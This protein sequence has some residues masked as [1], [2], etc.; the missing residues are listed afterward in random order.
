MTHRIFLIGLSSC[1]LASCGLV[2]QPELGDAVSGP[3]AVA[4]QAGTRNVFV[5]NSSFS[6]E[7][8][9]GSLLRFELNEAG[10]ALSKKDAI[11][12]PRLGAD[13]VG[14]ADGSLFAAAFSEGTSRLKFFQASRDGK[15]EDL[16]F[17]HPTPRGIAS[18]LQF[19]V[20]KEAKAGESFLTYVE[21]PGSIESRVVVLKITKA[22]VRT[23]L[24]LPDDLPNGVPEGYGFGYTAPAFSRESSVFVAFPQ[25]ATGLEPKLPPVFEYLKGAWNTV[26]KENADLR[27]VSMAVVQLDKILAGKK[28]SEASAF[29]PLVYN[30]DVRPADVKVKEDTEQNKTVAFRASYST[31]MGLDQMGC[32]E[33]K[34]PTDPTLL[35]DAVLVA[36]D[37][38]QDVIAFQGFDKARAEIDAFASQTELV[39]KR[40]R[41]RLLSQES[42]SFRVYS[43]RKDVPGI[44]TRE[45]HRISRIRVVKRGSDCVPVWIRT[46]SGRAS[47]GNELSRLQA[48]HTRAYNDP[49]KFEIPTRGSNRFGVLSVG[50]GESTRAF[51]VTASYSRGNI[52]AFEYKTVGKGNKSVNT[53]NG[54]TVKAEKGVNVDNFVQLK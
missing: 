30:A 7:Y 48:T 22:G 51:V 53:P 3:F 33:G 16:G 28:V 47:P 13:L 38:T 11:I 42:V 8:R 21:N 43:R 15:L 27:F 4:G 50:S 37:S 23:L 45:N 49:L 54:V 20:P 32:L 44:D 31:S 9:N 34:S 18:Q 14:S 35:A 2:E 29:R 24:T 46:E 5:L 17:E 6:G 26:K 10:T 41:E 19:F 36:D 40:H 12:V 1:L 25:G 39:G 52:H